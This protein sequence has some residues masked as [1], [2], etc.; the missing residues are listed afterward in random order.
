MPMAS[1]YNCRNIFS[2]IPI[3]LSLSLL[4]LMMKA[5]ECDEIVKY[6]AG[7]LLFHNNVCAVCELLKHIF[8][9]LYI[10]TCISQCISSTSLSSSL[11]PFLS[12]SLSS[13]LFFTVV[14]FYFSL[15]SLFLFSLEMQCEKN[16]IRFF[17]E[18]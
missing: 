1:F 7:L 8:D 15:Y 14:L 5:V 6:R 12:S 16:V 9:H 2:H 11:S 10:H 4:F 13:S 18:V 17:I 3:S